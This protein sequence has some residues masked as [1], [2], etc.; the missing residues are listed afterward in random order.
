MV[1]LVVLF[2]CLFL[3]LF[4]AAGLRRGEPLA[5][6]DDWPRNVAHRGASEAAPENTLEAFRKAGES[7]AGGLELDVHLSGDGRVVVIHDGVLART[8]DGSG[9]VR[10]K[11]LGALRSLDAGHRFAPGGTLDRKTAEDAVTERPYRGWGVRIPTLR[12][13]FEEFPQMTVNLDI[14]EDAPGIEEAVLEDIDRAGARDRVLVASQEGEVISRF[15]RLS[16]AD[17]YRVPTAASKWEVARFRA[18]SMLRL[19]GLVDPP[20]DAL[21]IPTEYGV[22]RFATR[23]FVEAAHARGVRVDVWTVDDPNEMARLL[24]LGTDSI[25]TNR[26]GELRQVLDRRESRRAEDMLY[27]AQ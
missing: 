3:V 14:K 5:V 17:G 24:D 10:D 21:Q 7:G 22:V 12:E 25:M 18:L 26:P 9:R 13:V 16:G 23:R 27:H 4:T 15:R 20:Y 6:G 1:V 11:T 8:T 19:E 2:L